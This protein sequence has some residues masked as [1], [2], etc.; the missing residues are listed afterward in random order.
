MTKTQAMIL[1]ANPMIKREY[2]EIQKTIKRLRRKRD[3]VEEEM[4]IELD[5]LNID[6][7]YNLRDKL[8]GI[9]DN[10]KRLDLI[11]SLMMKE[12]IKSLFNI[13]ELGDNISE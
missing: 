10:I 13:S 4:Y 9:I 7:Y 12:S 11:C 1:G 2:L 3:L 5:E 8:S 6:E